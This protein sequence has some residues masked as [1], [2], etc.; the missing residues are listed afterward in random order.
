MMKLRQ[1]ILARSIRQVSAIYSLDYRPELIARLRDRYSFLKVPTTVDEIF[2]TDPQQGLRF[3][4]GKFVQEKKSF[5]VELLQF[6]VIPPATNV[7]ICD[8]HTSTDDSD[9][10]LDDYIKQANLT[11][12]DMILVTE[13]PA[14]AS[15]LEFTM[16][17]SI[18]D[19]CHPPISEAAEG[20][21]RLLASYKAKLPAFE[22]SQIMMVYDQTG[23]GGVLATPFSVERRVGFRYGSNVFFSQA[24]LRTR[25]H[26]EVLERLTR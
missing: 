22:P 4:H 3:Q 26:I 14:Y 13:P 20:V 2:A 7:I 5:V 23:I 12:P 17:K 8:T 19:F 6:L 9:L 1:T 25:D 15:H 11:R 24:P 18:A 21:N 10:F 16:D